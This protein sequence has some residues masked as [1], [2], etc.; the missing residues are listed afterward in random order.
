[1]IDSH[2]TT[3]ARSKTHSYAVSMPA[4]RPVCEDAALAPAPVTPDFMMRIGLSLLTR[5]AADTK[6]SPS[7]IVSR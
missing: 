6:A 3:P 4:S 5:S 7:L 1:M 2:R